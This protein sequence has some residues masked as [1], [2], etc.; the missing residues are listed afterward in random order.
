MTEVR[1]HFLEHRSQVHLPLRHGNYPETKINQNK[2]TKER[3]RVREMKVKV[4]GRENNGR[5]KLRYR[6]KVLKNGRWRK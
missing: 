5:W 1:T 4:R 6:D 3:E 2:N